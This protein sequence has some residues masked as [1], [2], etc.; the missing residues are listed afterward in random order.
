MPGPSGDDK[1]PIRPTTSCISTTS[2]VVDQELGA[3]V[4]NADSC[5]AVDRRHKVGARR[6]RANGMI[7]VRL[8]TKWPLVREVCCGLERWKEACG[9]DDDFD[10]IWTDGP[11]TLDRIAKLRPYQRANHFLGMSTLS[12]KRS[13]CR[14]LSRMR[15]LFA[16]EYDFFPDT[17]EVPGD[18]APLK[19]FAAKNRQATYICKPANGAKGHGIFLTRSLSRVMAGVCPRGV[20]VQSYIDQPLLLD[21]QKFDLRL[22]VL[23]TSCEPLQVFLHREGLV[24]LATEAYQAPDAHN[25][26]RSTMHLTNY[27]INSRSSAFVEN[28]DPRD[29]RD[30]HKRSLQA[31]LGELRRGGLDVDHIMDG[32]EDLVV[33]T[34]LAVQPRLVEIDRRYRKQWSGGA[35]FELLGFDVLLDS[36]GTPWLLEVN[37]GPSFSGF[38][39]LDCLVKE[40]AVRGALALLAVSAKPRRQFNFV[41]RQE[42][43]RR[44]LGAKRSISA[45]LEVAAALL[46]ATPEEARCLGYKALY[47]SADATRSAAY[48]RYLAGAAEAWATGAGA[49]RAPTARRPPAS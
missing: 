37:H 35:S 20:V 10:L 46:P 25:M 17:W 31:V 38:S 3:D 27:D 28:S 21:G 14:N 24:R 11:L 32:I 47:P 9:K 22:Y 23:V 13:L 26:G 41:R 15:Q 29:G 7:M 49:A 2:H 12:C 5:G 44:A 42:L 8:E 40:S 33:K 39:D 16:D 19:R 4:A 45:G 18:I 48:A 43:A 34:L 6:A 36:A 1:G 30:G